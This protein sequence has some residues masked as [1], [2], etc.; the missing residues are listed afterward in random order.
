M[1][2]L[3]E[4]V[5][6]PDGTVVVTGYRA[7]AAVIRDNRLRKSPGSV[8]TA[9][10]YPD[11]ERLVREWTSVLEILNPLAVDTADAAAVQIQSYLRELVRVRR[12]R[13]ADDDG[14]IG[15]RLP[16]APGRPAPG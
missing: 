9:A 5:D 11:W 16:H 10:G 3:G 15:Q 2:A 14:T 13:P 4:A 12:E 1:H 8:L 6:A 7:S